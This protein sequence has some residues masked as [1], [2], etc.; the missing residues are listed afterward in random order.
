MPPPQGSVAHLCPEAREA[1]AEH[2]SIGFGPGRRLEIPWSVLA[3]PRWRRADNPSVSTF[4]IVFP[5]QTWPLGH[6]APPDACLAEVGASGR[7]EPKPGRHP[8]IY[9]SWVLRGARMPNGEVIHQTIS[10]VPAA[11]DVL[12]FSVIVRTRADRPGPIQEGVTISTVTVGTQTIELRRRCFSAP[13]FASCHVSGGKD[14]VF[15]SISWGRP[16]V[17]S[18]AIFAAAADL[19]DRYVVEGPRLG[20]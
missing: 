17:T 9:E 3:G 2:C 8:F 10:A 11:R 16:E 4:G 14:G 20:R 13:G 15:F 19:F 12:A 6:C 18:E 5:V 1:E 7:R